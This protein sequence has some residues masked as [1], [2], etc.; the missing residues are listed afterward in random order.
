MSRQPNGETSLARPPGALADFRTLPENVR[1]ATVSPWP[2]CAEALRY[3]MA[4]RKP[5][6]RRW[7][8]AP[9]YGRK[10]HAQTERKT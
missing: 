1:M 4:S 3:I 5:A 8:S 10:F 7:P 2:T 9:C 6:A